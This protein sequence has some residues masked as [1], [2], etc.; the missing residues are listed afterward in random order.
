MSRDVKSKSELI[1]VKN[2][3]ESNAICVNAK[4]RKNH[5]FSFA[6][7]QLCASFM[8]DAMFLCVEEM[9]VG[10][11]TCQYHI[12]CFEVEC[13]Y[14]HSGINP[15]GR[16]MFRKALKT[17]ENR[18]KAKAKIETDIEKHRNGINERW[19]DMTKC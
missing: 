16:R 8:T 9:R 1:M 12:K 11:P 6:Q 15:D 5:Y 18:E 7:R 14:N 4:C 13:P 17:H 2:Y 10:Q 19:E 3:C